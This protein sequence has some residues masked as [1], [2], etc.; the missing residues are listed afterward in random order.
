MPF[1][2]CDRFPEA[3]LDFDLP[4]FSAFVG[5]LCKQKFHFPKMKTDEKKCFLIQQTEL[6]QAKIKKE[7]SFQV[8]DAEVFPTFCLFSS[9]LFL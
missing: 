9:W 7:I 8:F 5:L 6:S 2:F 4:V 1:F 3:F